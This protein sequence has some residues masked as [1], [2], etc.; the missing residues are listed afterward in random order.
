[1]SDIVYIICRV[2]QGSVLGPL[3]FCIQPSTIGAILRYHGIGYHIMLTKH[4]SN[5]NI[6][7]SNL[8]F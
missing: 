6:Q 4:N 7:Y 2:P 3:K 8:F 1:M 5:N